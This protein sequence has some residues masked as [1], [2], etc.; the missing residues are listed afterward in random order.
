MY[1]PT[2]QQMGEATKTELF[3]EYGLFHMHI[4]KKSRNPTDKL[5]TK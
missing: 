3:M 1:I 5:N 4:H 2:G